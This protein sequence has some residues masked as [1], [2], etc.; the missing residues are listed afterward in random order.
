[1]ISLVKLFQ[2][3]SS[4]SPTASAVQFED[5]QSISYLDLDQ[6]SDLIRDKL[7]TEFLSANE[8]DNVI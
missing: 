6:L 3:H 7:I 1:M 5:G 4:N 8:V 2:S